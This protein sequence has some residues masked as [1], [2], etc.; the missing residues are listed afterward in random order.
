MPRNQRVIVYVGIKNSVV[1][2]DEKTGAEMWRA[3]LH[4]SDYVTVLWDGEALFASNGGEVWR[5]DPVTGAVM[6][7][8][9]LKGLGRG[10]VS[11]A[12]SRR[13]MDATDSSQGAAKRRHDA[14]AAAAG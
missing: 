10:V 6:W 2:L 3:R 4:G 5:L 7:H 1:A 14:Q 13:G 8:N 11:L 12:S 9:A